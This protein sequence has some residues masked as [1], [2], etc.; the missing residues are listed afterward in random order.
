MV[1]VIS[2]ACFNYI[3]LVLELTFILQSSVVVPGPFLERFIPSSEVSDK[4]SC[5]IR[6]ALFL[7]QGVN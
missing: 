3:L 2:I 6:H 1:N 7:N 4:L 5:F